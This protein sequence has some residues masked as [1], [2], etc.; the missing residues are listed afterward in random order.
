MQTKQTQLVSIIVPAKNEEENIPLLYE[1]VSKSLVNHSWELIVIDDG[2][3]DH[4]FEKLKE[5]AKKDSRVR[6]IQFQKNFKKSAAYM[7]GFAAAKGEIIITMDADLQD[8][9]REL[10][11]FIQEIKNNDLVVGWKYKRQDPAT[12]VIASR[13]FNKVNKVLFGLHIHDFD[14]GYRAMRSHVVKD[15]ALYGDLYRYIPALVARSGYRV[16][17]IQ[18]HHQP[19]KFGKS[20]YGAG[21]LITGAL[22]LLTV[23]F[24]VDYNQRPLHLFGGAGL[25]SFGVGFLAELYVVYCRLIIGDLFVVHLPALIFGVLMMIMG[26]QLF[27]IGLIGE[28]VSS[29][30]RTQ[31][32]RVKETVN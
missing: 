17:E 25:L 8:D 7:A 15:L 9:P 30:S 16:G 26:V 4:T 18:V 14:C 12:K 10:P 23:K 5:I 13:I 24:I 32:Y 2:S 11:K 27:G 6:G 19:R 3:T 22:D 28:L 29:I 21:R 20:K 31:R 1:A